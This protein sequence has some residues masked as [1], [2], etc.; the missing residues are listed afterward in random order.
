MLNLIATIICTAGAVAQ[1]NE[2]W[3]L[4]SVCAIFAVANSIFG[5]YWIKNKIKNRKAKRL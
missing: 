5:F 3:A 4:F 1:W 2:N